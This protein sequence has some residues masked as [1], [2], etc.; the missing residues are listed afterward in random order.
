MF[1]RADHFP[2]CST[3]RPRETRSCNT[4]T[5]KSGLPSVSVQ[6]AGE[7]FE[8]TPSLTFSREAMRHVLHDRGLVESSQGDL[9]AMAFYAQALRHRL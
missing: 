5:M 2:A 4:F 7:I 9:A 8:R 6:E 3:S 1:E